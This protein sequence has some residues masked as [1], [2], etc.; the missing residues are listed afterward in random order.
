MTHQE[1]SPSKLE[2]NAMII[3]P[4]VGTLLVAALAFWLN[5]MIQSW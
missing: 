1:P 3:L 4:F 2:L 5:Q